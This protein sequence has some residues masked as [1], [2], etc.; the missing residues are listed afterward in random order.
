MAEHL[1]A[2]EVLAVGEHGL[3]AVTVVVVHAGDVVAD[4]LRAVAALVA[5]HL[6]EATV[7]DRL[8]AADNDSL[9]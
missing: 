1:L 6:E 4:V 8:E 2:A 7:V 3:P 5:V 9:I